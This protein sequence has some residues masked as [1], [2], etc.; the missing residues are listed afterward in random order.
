MREGILGITYLPPF[1]LP[2]INQLEG[3]HFDDL[4]QK[5]LPR[6]ENIPYTLT[7]VLYSALD[8]GLCMLN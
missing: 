1:F 2:T 5:V 8:G 3:C 4:E 6:L 7:L